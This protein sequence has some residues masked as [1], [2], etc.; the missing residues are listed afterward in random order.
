VD[1]V[2]NPEFGIEEASDMDDASFL[3]SGHQATPQP[4]TD[5]VALACDHAHLLLFANCN[6]GGGSATS[7]MSAT[8]NFQ[9]LGLNQIITE[10]LRDDPDVIDAVDDDE[11]DVE[12]DERGLSVMSPVP[13]G[14]RK[15]MS[16]PMSKD[17]A[18]HF[19]DFMMSTSRDP[20][21][22]PKHPILLESDP[23]HESRDK[24]PKVSKYSY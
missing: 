6:D 4:I 19:E 10:A 2:G 17:K 5:S 7:S 8:G 1:A 24:S 22:S 14:M 3:E 21:T 20:A 9:Q 23:G 13:K 16:S 12:I 18:F 15:Q 11:D